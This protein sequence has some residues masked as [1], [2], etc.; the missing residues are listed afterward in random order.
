MIP[1]YNIEKYRKHYFKED[2]EELKI[3]F[4]HSTHSDFIK[5]KRD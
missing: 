1:E 2:F 4:T 3:K 5:L